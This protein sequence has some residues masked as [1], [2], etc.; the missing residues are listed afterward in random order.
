M[1]P[2]TIVSIVRGGP[3]FPCSEL[4]S[5]MDLFWLYPGLAAADFEG[6]GLEGVWLA[7]LLSRKTFLGGLGFRV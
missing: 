7:L 5:C 1:S 2:S 6:S 3:S 4:F